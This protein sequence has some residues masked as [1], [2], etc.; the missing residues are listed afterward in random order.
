MTIQKVEIYFEGNIGS[1]TEFVTPSNLLVTSV[2]YSNI[3]TISCLEQQLSL[4]NLRYM[5]N[6]GVQLAECY[7]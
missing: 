7:V 2:A 3:F 6:I 5:G 1:H 4:M